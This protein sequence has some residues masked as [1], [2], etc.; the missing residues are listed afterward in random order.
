MEKLEQHQKF[1]LC[2]QK[3]LVGEMADTTVDL[4]RLV[5]QKKRRGVRLMQ[6]RFA[7]LSGA[8]NWLG[9]WLT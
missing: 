4:L 2:A 1:G 9:N 5:A 3:K 6:R 7:R 8:E